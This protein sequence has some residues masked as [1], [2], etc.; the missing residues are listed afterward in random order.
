MATEKHKFMIGSDLIRGYI[1]EG[2]Q[3]A[4]RKPHSSPWPGSTC[5]VVDN[6]LFIDFD[7]EA[8][9]TQLKYTRSGEDA[10]IN[11]TKC[12]MKGCA[13]ERMQKFINL[14]FLGRPDKFTSF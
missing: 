11:K 9:Q 7:F 14:L 8:K 6:F 2:A 3:C 12:E 10:R 4:S 1:C 13:T 5:P